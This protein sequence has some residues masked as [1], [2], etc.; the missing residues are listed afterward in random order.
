MNNE[1]NQLSNAC[2][3]IREM[4]HQGNFTK[5]EDR[6]RELMM[7][8]PDHAAPHNLYGIIKELEGYRILAMKHYRVAWALDNRYAPARHN[9]ERLASLE[10][11][12]KIAFV[13]SDIVKVATKS[14][15]KIEYDERGVGHIVKHNLLGW[16]G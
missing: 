13:E 1:I 15:M 11:T 16:Q 2:E 5:S 12:E 10:K 8:Y 9:M 14:H 3:E 7:L 6:V 4:V